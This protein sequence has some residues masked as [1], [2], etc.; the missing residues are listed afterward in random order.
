MD[1]V[2]FYRIYRGAGSVDAIDFATPIATVPANGQ[3]IRLAAIPGGWPAG[4]TWFI[5][6]RSV[7]AAGVEFA[8]PRAIARAEFDA[9]GRLLPARPGPVSDLRAAATSGSRLAASWRYRGD[10]DQPPPARF[11]LFVASAAA[12]LESMLS[13]TPA[14]PVTA[15]P[16]AENPAWVYAWTSPGLASGLWR[17]AVRALAPSGAAGDGVDTIAAA[18]PSR[19]P[20]IPL[21]QAEVQ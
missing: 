18:T 12:T 10:P 13:S 20:N 3:P 14:A 17:V 4:V 5:A 21:L 6:V 19:A 16:D 1:N 9:A 2:A 15:E 11:E 8:Q 7:D